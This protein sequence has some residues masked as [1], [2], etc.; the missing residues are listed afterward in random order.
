[1]DM[2]IV[3]TS[4]P[5]WKPVAAD[6][7]DMQGIIISAYPEQ[8]F[9]MLLMVQFPDA[10]SARPWLT[11]VATRV[12]KASGPTDS[13]FN[14]ALSASG[15]RTVE[16]P[17]PV[18]ETF[19]RSFQE[20]MTVPERSRFL[21]DVDLQAPTYWSWNDELHHPLCVHAQLMLYAKDE[22]SLIRLVA[23]ETDAL[24][25]HKVILLNQIAQRVILRPDGQRHEHFGF[26][27]GISQPI[28]VDGD[29]PDDRRALHE[30]AAGEVVIGQKNTY[31]IPAPGPLVPTTGTASRHLQPATLNGFHDLGRNGT[32]LVLRQMRQNVAGFWKGMEEQS[33][34]LFTESGEQADAEWLAKKAVGRTRTGEL[35]TLNGS[36]ADNNAAFFATDR[37]G[38]G[39]PITSHV[40][41]SNPRD[42]L[43]PKKGDV[44][45][46]IRATNRHRIMRRGRV[47]GEPI[48]D[49][50]VDDGVDRGLIF[51]CLNSD[52]E[53]QF[54]FIQHT[55]LLN[56]A[57]GVQ[58]M[59]SDPIIGP[60]CPFTIPSKPLRQRPV[61]ETFITVCGGGYFFVPSL[62]A[63]RYLGAVA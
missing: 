28:L 34:S 62:G 10:A 20:G 54:E 63:I 48:A 29:V 1:M 61:L 45:D 53:R 40:R 43:A 5:E 21:G 24:Q 18:M 35:L 26:A 22:V 2:S 52:P 42:G 33:A 9:A 17:E 56:P 8:I 36:T 57:F 15:L 39:C 51:A 32:Y 6:A 14:I 38:F 13:C 3:S 12:T 25:Q 49:R 55:W 50:T 58:Y 60:R 7:A 4:N 19:D 47:Y 27:D 59:E 11:K 31:G 16:V 44:K 23:R 46:I 37:Q 30:I 41:R